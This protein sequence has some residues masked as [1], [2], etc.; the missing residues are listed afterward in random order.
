MLRGLG[1]A[2]DPAWTKSRPGAEITLRMGIL[3]D[4]GDERFGHSTQ[5]A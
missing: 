4:V 3:V 5:E 1:R 2:R